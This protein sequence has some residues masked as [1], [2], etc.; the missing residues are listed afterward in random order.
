MC[1]PIAFAVVLLTLLP[2][3]ADENSEHSSFNSYAFG[4]RY[5]TTVTRKAL[6]ASPVWRDDA[7]NP[8]LSAR[9][10][11]KLADALRATLVKDTED[12]AWKRESAE[13]IFVEHPDR[14]FWRV[15]Y[16]A[17]VKVGSSTGM[18]PALDLFVLMDG[19]ILHPV[20]SK[21]P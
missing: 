2:C 18:P 11:I 16:E 13:I 4:K 14:C 20:V 10:A 21:S 1:R 5:K 19:T 9:K 3:R 8:P 15:H 12:Y 17:H 6:V 7:D